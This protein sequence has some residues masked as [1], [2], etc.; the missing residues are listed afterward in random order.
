MAEIETEETFRINTEDKVT[1]SVE[2]AKL[3]LSVIDV[4]TK[5][6]GFMPREFTTIGKIYDKLNSFVEKK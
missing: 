5:R 2:D 1:I 6:G 4:I 3:M